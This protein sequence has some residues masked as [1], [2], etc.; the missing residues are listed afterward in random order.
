LIRY[1]ARI[2]AVE[3]V[4]AIKTARKLILN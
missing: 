1:A 4:I 2:K 3:I